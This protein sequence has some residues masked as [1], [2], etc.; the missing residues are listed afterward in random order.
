MQ[1]TVPIDYRDKAANI[2]HQRV[3]RSELVAVTLFL[4]FTLSSF[5]AN[6]LV[7]FL[8]SCEIFTRLR[9]LTLLHT[10]SDI[11]MHEGTL[12][13][14]EIELVI[15]TREHLC[16]GSRVTDHANCAHHFRKITSWDDS[17]WLVV[18]ATFETSW[19]PVP[20]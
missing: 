14:H 16:N 19:T 15:D 7:I 9:E 5:D 11:P 1:S 3:V 10:L 8:Q 13:I 17:W 2:T 18:D 20:M 6:L 4:T 12:G